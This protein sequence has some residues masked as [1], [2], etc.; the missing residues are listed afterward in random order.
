MEKNMHRKFTLG[1]KLLASEYPGSQ[2]PP[3]Y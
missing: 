2:V 3:G 1:W